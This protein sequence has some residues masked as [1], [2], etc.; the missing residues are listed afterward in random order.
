MADRDPRPST[1]EESAPLLNDRNDPSDIHHQ[2][3]PS[4]LDRLGALVHEPLTALNKLLLVL[5]LAFLILSSVFIGLFAGAE[6]KLKAKPPPGLP[7]PREITVTNIVPVP[8]TVIETVT[9]APPAPTAPPHEDACLTADC[10]KLSAAILSSL[11]VTQDPCENFYDFVTGGWRKSHPLPS[12]K[13]R[14]GIFNVLFQENQEIVR[15][16]LE[17]GSSFSFDVS[18]SA[19][20]EL[21]SKL[22]NA[23]TSC[24]DEDTLDEF[25]EGPLK[26]LSRVIKGLFR[27]DSTEIQ[28]SVSDADKKRDGLT[29]ALAYLH[30]KGLPGLFDLSIEGDAAVDP[31]FMVL[32]FSQP[33]S[34]GL[35]SKEYFE[36]K[37][38]RALYRNVLSRLISS[39]YNDDESASARL[40]HEFEE[41]RVS[42][43]KKQVE[44]PEHWLTAD[45][46]DEDEVIPTDASLGSAR[47]EHEIADKPVVVNGD[48][49]NVW[50]PWPWPPWG[51]DDDG[52]D[53]G[54]K[55]RPVD[56]ETL[57]HKVTKFERKLARASLDLDKLYQD[58]F[59]TYNKVPIS[60]LTGTLKQ[61]NF[62]NYFASFNPRNYPEEVVIT[63]PAYVTSLADIL[64]ETEDEVLEAYFVTRAALSLA[65]LLS[66]KTESWKAVRSLQEFL[67]GIKPGAVG[68][69]AEFC[70]NKVDQALG[71]AAGRFFV[72]ETF[73]AESKDRGTKV[74]KDIVKSFKASLEN[75]PW[76]DEESAAAAANKADALRIKVGYPLSPNTTRAESLL[77]YY[78]LVKIDKHTF[79]DNM[80][81]ASASDVYKTWQ[82]LGKRRDLQG[83]EM[84]PAT[85]NAY[86]NP[87]GNEIV[88]PAGI[89]RP[90]FFSKDWPSYLQYGAFGMVAAH[91]LTHAFDSA[92]RLYNQDGKLEEWWT[93]A[94]SEGFNEK[95]SCMEKQYSS[96]YVLDDKGEK[97]Y[98]NGNLTSGENIGDS[99]II[100]TYRAWKAQYE[101]SYQAGHEYLLPGLNF[102]R[103]QLF[104]I[105]FG[106]EWAEN[107]KPA[108][109]VQR[110]RTDPHSPNEFRV[111]GTLYNVPEFAK[112]FDCPVGSKLNPPPEKRCL[113]WS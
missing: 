17:E 5:L 49:A 40:A 61:I 103:E 99:G 72:N 108:S 7:P 95:A 110:V 18:S 20:E 57:A 24:T 60:N 63:Y 37:S 85:V 94:T 74:I 35:P 39:L 36:D 2:R 46:G 45:I 16:I 11:D 82:T 86:Y 89:M 33:G 8:T 14:L 77:A 28:S 50:P 79:F 25:G 75:I 80:V 52:D 30:S 66:M 3:H 56:P 59:G 96:Y 70:V 67:Q 90:P 106:R 98:V 100:Q 4:F 13:G 112:A 44:N 31:N 64:D 21:L 92:G 93:N 51:G 55:P 65:P 48:A 6:H 26:E 102:T 68:D 113:L 109:L 27:G 15:G 69:R 71:F 111:E 83:W 47:P 1:D 9:V 53:G 101:E 62:G 97:V 81:S 41:L 88:F 87:P 105:S 84:T 107:I 12:D 43:S 78:S 73:G 91:E 10:V 22:R 29:A 54:S 19:D 23:Y 34:F 38:I 32:W 58:P 76:M 42:L 104:F